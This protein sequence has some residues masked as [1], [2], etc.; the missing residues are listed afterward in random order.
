[1]LN[2][3]SVFNYFIIFLKYTFILKSKFDENDSR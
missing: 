1:M 2:V 3:K